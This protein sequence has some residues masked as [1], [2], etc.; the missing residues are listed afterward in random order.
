MRSS[1][2]GDDRA[3]AQKV[4]DAGGIERRRHH[5]EAQVVAR[6]PRLPCERQPEVRVDAALVELVQHDRAKVR[7][8]GILLQAG[9]Q[10]PFRGDEQSCARREP[11]LEPDVPAHLLPEGPALLVGDAPRHGSRRYAAWLQQDDRAVLHQ[12]RRDTRGL[13]GARRRGDDDGAVRAHRQHRD[14]VEVVV[15]GKWRSLA[16]YSRRAARGPSEPVSSSIT[17]SV[18]QCGMSTATAVSELPKV[19]VEGRAGDVAGLR[20]DAGDR[21]L[22]RRAA[23]ARLRHQRPAGRRRPRRACRLAVAT[24]SRAAATSS[25]GPGSSSRPPGRARCRRPSPSAPGLAL[26]ASAGPARDAAALRAQGRGHARDG[27]HRACA[28]GSTPSSSAARSR[29][30]AR[31]SPPTSTTPSSSR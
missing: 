3:A 27:V 31:S 9:R 21:A 13:A 4:R 28:K 22:G 10:N 24:G 2:H 29:A 18:Q 26:K 25:K 15:D 19:Y 8:Q 12:R 16:C 20:A 11:S 30:A 6:T 5:D 14:A 23:A 1:W 7:Q 17:M